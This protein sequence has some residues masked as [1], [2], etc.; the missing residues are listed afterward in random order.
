MPSNAFEFERNLP[1]LVTRRGL[2]KSAGALAVAGGTLAR[3]AQERKSS[4]GKSLFAYVGTYSSPQGPEGSKGR[5]EG[6]YLYRADGA[7][8]VLTP[9][10]LFK[11]NA[12]PACLALNGARTHLYSANETSTYEGKKSGSVGAYSVDRS[13]GHLTLVNTVSS[14][15]AGP[16]HLSVH[17]SDRYVLVANYAGG[18]IAV[19]P[20][21]ANGGLGEPTDVKEDPGPVGSEHAT[22]APPGSFAISGH[23]HPHA[24]MIQSDP[25]GRFVVHTDLAT[26][27]IYVWRFDAEKGTLSAAAQPFVKVPTGDGPRHFAFHPN[28]RW[29]Y[30]LQEEA[31]TLLHCDYDSATGKLTPRET[32]SSLPKGFAGSNFTSE[33]AISPDARFLYA[34]NRLHD[35]IAHFSI[36]NDGQLSFAGEAWTRGDYP[37]TFTIDPTGNFL[38]SCNQRA[39]AITTFR[40]NRRT[41]ALTFTDQYTHVGTPGIIVFL[42]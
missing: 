38:Y 8:G 21:Q 26:D 15:G 6:I 12:N 13:T 14:Q 24:H 28:G 18:T 40:V 33:I 1:E 27:R 35:S 10:D 22:S 7:T 23:D 34:A 11:N 29:F 19:L 9:V 37:R 3:A 42:R 36:G 30:C 20:I 41:G 4:M 5:G 31:S 25:S 16:A 39:D 17:P 2:L 32:I